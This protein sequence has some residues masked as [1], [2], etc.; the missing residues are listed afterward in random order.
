MANFA[1]T[2][3]VSENDNP[4]IV[5]QALETAI[6]AV[7]TA[8]TIRSVTTGFNPKSGRFFGILLQDT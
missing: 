4:L 3:T 6:E 5:A 7:D 1:I 2:V 8:K